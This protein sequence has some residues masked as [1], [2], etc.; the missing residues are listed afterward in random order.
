MTDRE[1]ILR[2]AEKVMGWARISDWP[3][4]VSTLPRD[5]YWKLS[6]TPVPFC[7]WDDKQGLIVYHERNRGVTWNPLESDADAFMLVDALRPRGW[8]FRVSETGPFSEGLACARFWRDDGESRMA[9][10]NNRCRAIVL[11][12]IR[13]AKVPA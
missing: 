10:A 13:A 5:F 1:M 7:L 4:E 2:A 8:K 11:A 3:N 6:N 12:A 9:E